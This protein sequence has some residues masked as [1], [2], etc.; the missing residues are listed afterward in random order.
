[1][2]TITDD[3]K[4]VLKYVEPAIT[5]LEVIQKITGTGGL[6]A[7]EALVAINA[8]IKVFVDGVANDVTPASILADLATL[9]K[10]EAADDA[11]ADAAVKAKFPAP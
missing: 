10:G 9:T 6:P 4:S 7:E 8:A 2:S 3:L 5:T 11:A 1:M